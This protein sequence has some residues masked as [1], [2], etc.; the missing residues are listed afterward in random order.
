MA[1]LH[2]VGEITSVCRVYFQV[3]AFL[4]EFNHSS[5]TNF[6]LIVLSRLISE[7]WMKEIV[8]NDKTLFV[9]GQIA[10]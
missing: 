9:K 6:L 7:K 2:K 10:L 5:V 4:V 1:S 8:S 3:V